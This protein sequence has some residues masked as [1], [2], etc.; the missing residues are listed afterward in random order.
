MA[1]FEDFERYFDAYIP[2]DRRIPFELP[3]LTTQLE[4]VGARSVLDIGCGSGRHAVSLAEAGYEVAGIDPSERLLGTAREIASD[5]GVDIRFIR[6]SV[7]DLHTGSGGLRASDGALGPRLFDAC[8][9]LGNTLPVLGDDEELVHSLALCGAALKP[10]GVLIAQMPNYRDR[11]ARRDPST[12]FRTAVVDGNRYMLI[13]ALTFRDTKSGDSPEVTLHLL[14]ITE[15]GGEF[16]LEDRAMVINALTSDR[17]SSLLSSA[18]FSHTRFFG[19][20]DGSDYEPDSP[21]LIVVTNVPMKTGR[22]ANRLKG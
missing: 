1:Q 2:W 9:I 18:G 5:E 10:G 3:F 16:T 8:L 20:M 15:K 22:G 14:S 6:A 17:V 7:A 12:R 11:I 21:D 13:K 19:S 4:R